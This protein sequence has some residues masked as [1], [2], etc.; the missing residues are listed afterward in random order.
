MESVDLIFLKE[1][2]YNME[3]KVQNCAKKKV[4]LHDCYPFYHFI[5]YYCSR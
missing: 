4:A 3:S 1:M 2:V 5:Y